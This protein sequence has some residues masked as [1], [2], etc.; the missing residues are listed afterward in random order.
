MPLHTDT[1]PSYPTMIFRL[2]APCKLM[3]VIITCLLGPKH[4]EMSA[5]TILN[6][7]WQDEDVSALTVFYFLST[8]AVTIL[9]SLQSI[10]QCM[11]CIMNG[12]GWHIYSYLIY[13]RIWTRIHTFSYYTFMARIWTRIHS[14]GSF[15]CDEGLPGLIACW[16]LLNEMEYG[17]CFFIYCTCRLDCV[18][19]MSFSHVTKYKKRR[20]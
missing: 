16:L 7:H 13:S 12:N 5:I 6:A 19:M 2:C 9:A 3:T 1:W 18:W 14:F 10:D 17:F 4:S 15:S 11:H 20:F 8:I